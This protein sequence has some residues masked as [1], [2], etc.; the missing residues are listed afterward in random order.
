[1]L[2]ERV[3]ASNYRDYRLS[4]ESRPDVPFGR[5]GDVTDVCFENPC[6]L[7]PEESLKFM[8]KGGSEASR[9]LGPCYLELETAGGV[10]WVFTLM[11]QIMGWRS[12][13]LADYIGQCV[14]AREDGCFFYTLLGVKPLEARKVVR[15]GE[16][17]LL[18][19][20]LGDVVVELWKT[21]NKEG[22]V[23]F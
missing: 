9:L 11:P 5:S 13:C 12:P 19:K 14:F 22:E 15:R 23:C 10:E 6:R 8:E 4:L 16:I 18:W 2:S 21:F 7:T 17:A 20:M 3:N 1:M